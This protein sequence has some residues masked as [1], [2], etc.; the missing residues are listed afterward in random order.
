MTFCREGTKNTTISRSIQYVKG[1]MD[2]GNASAIE[3]VK[4]N[5]QN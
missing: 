4:I 2:L 5:M 3:S 1:I